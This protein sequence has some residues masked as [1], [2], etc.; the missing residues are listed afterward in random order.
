MKWDA[1]TLDLGRTPYVVFNLKRT[2]YNLCVGTLFED[3]DEYPDYVEMPRLSVYVYVP[4]K[5][6]LSLCLAATVHGVVAHE[7]HD[8]VPHQDHT[9]RLVR[10]DAISVSSTSGN[11]AIA[12][13][14][15]RI[16]FR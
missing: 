4:R 15:G 13:P 6:I 8:H 5:T 11:Q 16:T 1:K 7:E 9:P 12:I 3:S 2:C 10:L 14:S